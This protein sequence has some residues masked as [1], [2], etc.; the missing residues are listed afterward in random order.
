M[1]TSRTNPEH[2]SKHFIWERLLREDQLHLPRIRI[3]K[4]NCPNLW[5][6]MRNTRTK[7]GRNGEVKKDKSSEKKKSILRQHAT[8][9]SDANDAAVVGRYGHLMQYSGGLL[10]DDSV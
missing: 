10:P 2:A 5:I 1:T 3:N 9:L 7:T 4:A 6:S 8:D